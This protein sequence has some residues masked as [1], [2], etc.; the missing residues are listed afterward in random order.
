[1]PEPRRARVCVCVH[2]AQRGAVVYWLAR[3]LG[4][5]LV[6]GSIPGP[7]MFHN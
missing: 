6:G 1:M 7:G 5:P 3:P 2:S 4:M